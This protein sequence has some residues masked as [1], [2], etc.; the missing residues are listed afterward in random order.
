M[1]KKIL[2]VVLALVFVLSA[3]TVSAFANN[4]SY[5]EEEGTSYTQTWALEAN[6]NGDGT[7]KVSVMLTTNYAVG[8]I[9]FKIY[10]S[11]PKV[12]LDKEASKIGAAIPDT[13]GATLQCNDENGKVLIIP[14][15]DMG[16]EAVELKEG[17]VI[18]ELVYNVPDGEA[19]DLEIKASDAKTGKNIDGTLI[20]L[21]VADGVLEEGAMVYGQNVVAD[22]ATAH[23]GS[24]AAPAD[25]AKKATAEAGI[26]IDTAHTF[27][28]TY[29]GVVYGF[30]QKANNTFVNTNYITT[31]LE[32]TNGGSLAFSR[33]IGATGYGTGTVITV[34]NA[35]GSE[36][37]KYVVVIFGDIDGN[38]LTNVNDTKAVQKAAKVASTYANNTVQRMAA[39]CQNVAAAAMMHTINVNDTKAVQA[40]A[41]G[42]RVDQAALAAKMASLTA[43]YK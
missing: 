25:L 32:A 28:G 37:A 39:N 41:K 42:A 27:G 23:I 30:K 35:D 10:N 31:N 43:Y 2:S 3:F 33:S 9:Q 8:A 1:S 12:T 5:A 16:A 34:K 19:A 24:E 7:W 18:A 20:A 17:S 38:G 15:P 4:N 26:I 22:D 13:Y 11:N 36:A 40:N 21:R 29:T 6:D 14:N